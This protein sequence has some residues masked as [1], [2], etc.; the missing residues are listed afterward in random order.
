MGGGNTAQCP[1]EPVARKG[2]LRRQGK[3]SADANKFSS[4][5]PS[6][7]CLCFPFL[8]LLRSLEVQFRGGNG[9]H[10]CSCCL[11]T[12]I[13]PPSPSIQAQR[14]A[15][16]K[17]TAGFW[18]ERVRKGK[19]NQI[20]PQRMEVALTERNEK[21]CPSPWTELLAW[22]WLSAGLSAG[23]GGSSAQISHPNMSLFC[24]VLMGLALAT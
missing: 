5:F 23:S 3:T 15:H 13:L 14:F 21:F 1:Q 4:F 22:I 16:V 17:H 9:V 7:L 8:F 18:K 11:N 2:G 24:L 12:G 6:A 10:E 20:P 19:V